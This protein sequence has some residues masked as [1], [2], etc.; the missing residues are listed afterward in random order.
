MGDINLDF[1]KGTRTD[2]S[3]TDSTM[4][5]KPLTEA[6]FS[7]IIPH[8][9]SQLVK[10]ATRVWPG[11]PDSGLDHIYSNNPEK[12]SAITLEF[13][14]GS[15]H[16]LL[17]FTRF[18]K[19]VTRSVKYVRKRSFKNFNSEEFMRAVRLLSWFDLYMCQDPTQATELLTRKL[20]DLLDTMAP[21]RTIQVRSKY[22][23]WLSDHTKAMLKLR[24]A[25]RTK[26]QDDWREYK[27]LRNS[28][29]ARMRAEKKSWEKQ[30]LDKAQHSSSTLWQNVKSWLNWGN[31][32]PP[33][34]LF[35]NGIIVNKPA[36]V[37]TIMNEF[38]INKVNQLRDR[39][40]VADSDP[41][42]KLREFLQDKNCTFSLKPVSP[43]EVNEIVTGL[44]N[45]KSTGMDF[46]DTWVVKL[47]QSEILP[48]LTHIVNISISQAEFP[49]PWK[50]SK[51]VPLL[52]KGDP[53]LTK[54]YRPVALL[55]FKW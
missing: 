21:V 7:R 26:N 5:L 8:G 55:P 3:S 47:I 14:G 9:I 42:E 24:D 10:E 35:N 18:A 11:Q 1:L 52:K 37:A 16:K 53:L 15:D 13:S 28:A 29:T 27:N 4:R 31:S 41:L 39:I 2:L 40:S 44:K 23:A 20:T 54:N 48:A 32:G 38:F 22:A 17:K 50:I 12:C 33:S 43:E 19:S 30:K 45:T 25:A 34:K 46:I 49:L 36:R 6:L 51:V